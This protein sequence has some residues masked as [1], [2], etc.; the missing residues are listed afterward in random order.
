M[1]WYHRAM[2]QALVVI[3]V[4]AGI[5]A[6]LYFGTDILR[7]EPGEAPIGSSCRPTGCSGQVCADH[8]VVTTC[9]FRPEYACYRTARCERQGDGTCG[10][11]MTPQLQQCLNAAR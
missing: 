1:I 6:V 2:K 10:W 5:L 11:T 9:E 8:D 4:I 7:R 3:L